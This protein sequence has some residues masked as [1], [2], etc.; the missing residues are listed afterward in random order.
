MRVVHSKRK[1]PR[2]ETTLSRDDNFDYAALLDRTIGVC[3][4]L[5]EAENA[6]NPE[7][8]KEWRKILSGLIE[9]AR[10]VIRGP[11]I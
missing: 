5:L 4:A 8:V 2:R 1:R 9:I 10:A 3:D 6:N 7:L 11:K